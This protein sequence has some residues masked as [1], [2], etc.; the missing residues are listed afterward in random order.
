MPELPRIP[1]A[2][3]LGGVAAPSPLREQV[4]H[5]RRLGFRGVQLN[6]ASPEAR[7]RDLER[8]ARRDLAALLRRS[9]LLCA[10]VDL[11][12]PPAHFSDPARVDR[13]VQAMFEAI[14]FTAEVAGL[15]GGRA[16][17]GTALPSGEQA[18]SVIAALA[19]RARSRTVLLADCSWPAQDGAGLAP[20]RPAIGID[21][22]AL[23]LV[24]AD[25]A[26]EILRLGASVA[27]ARL[28]DIDAS[29]RVAPGDGR[30][31]LLG[32]LVALSMRPDLH[33]A[34]FDPRGIARPDEAAQRTIERCGLAAG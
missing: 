1:I 20:G 18:A 23:I 14:D 26:A 4:E 29:G 16:V 21:P 19:D 31:D 12:I 25:P 22:A 7:P 28:S 33:P 10:G 32:Y 2:L 34:V 27:A 8:S 17:I 6:A 3:A 5:A 15:A 24:G 13:A 9:E 30:L 11:F